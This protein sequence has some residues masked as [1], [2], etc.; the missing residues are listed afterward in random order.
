M[1]FHRSSLITLLLNISSGKTVTRLDYQAYSKLAI[2]TMAKILRDTR[3]KFTRSTHQTD[4]EPVSAVVKSV[5]YHRLGTVPVGEPSIVIA[6]SSPHRK[7]SF[8]ACEHILEEVKEKVQIWKREFY[9]GE[10]ED[11]AEWKTNFAP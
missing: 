6:V 3:E 11:E 9:D 10:E 7:E 8:L 1:S 4:Q 2:K 5:V